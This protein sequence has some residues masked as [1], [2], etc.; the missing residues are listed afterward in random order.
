VRVFG[1]PISEEF[2]EVSPAD[3]KVHIMQYFERARFEWHQ[4]F[5]GTP[6]QVQLGLIGREWLDTQNH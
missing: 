1:Y 2:D 3:G 5:A 6:Q 4:E